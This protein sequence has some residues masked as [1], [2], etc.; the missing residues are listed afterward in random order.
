VAFASV[1]VLSATLGLG[2]ACGCAWERVVVESFAFALVMFSVA[3]LVA[4]VG[5][6]GSESSSSSESQLTSSVELGFV[7]AVGWKRS[8]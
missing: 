1:E 4:R 6:L 7:D 3:G 2:V 8:G 5:P